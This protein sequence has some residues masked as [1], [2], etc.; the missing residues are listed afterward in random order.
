MAARQTVMSCYGGRGVITFSDRERYHPNLEPCDRC[1]AWLW[2]R[3]EYL[4]LTMRIRCGECNHH[5][6]VKNIHIR[7]VNAPQQVKDIWEAWSSE[8]YKKSK[9]SL[10]IIT[11]IA[12]TDDADGIL[13]AVRTLDIVTDADVTQG[14]WVHVA[15]VPFS[16]WLRGRG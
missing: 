9:Q 2:E 13:A 12:V 6:A 15:C 11:P 7:G 5:I 16:E 1:G 4:R 3:D 10:Q 14:D 8:A